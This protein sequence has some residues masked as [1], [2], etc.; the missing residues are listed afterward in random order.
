MAMGYTLGQLAERFD[1]TLRGEA[2]IQIS[3]LAPLGS[4]QSGQLTFLK[5]RRLLTSLSACQAAAVILS[6]SDA[7]TCPLACLISQNPHYDF[8]RVAALFRTADTVE[9]GVHPTA[10]V[11]ENCQLDSTASIGPYCVIGD[12]VK[13]GAGVKLGSHCVLGNQIQIAADT[14]LYARVTIGRDTQ[15]GARCVI[16]SG[17]VI[18]GEGFGLV[19]HARQWHAV[20]QLAGVRIG[21]D[22]DVGA[23][24]TIDRGALVNTCIEDGVKLDNQ[25][26]IGHGVQIG[27]STVIAGCV[28]IGGST[29]IGQGCMIGGKSAIADHLT[30]ADGVIIHGHARVSSSVKKAGEYGSGM[31]LLPVGVWRRLRVRYQQLET[32]FA[33]VA[34]LENEE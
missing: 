18:G 24:T 21:S 22:V 12:D 34:K 19:H 3:S 11:G 28:G 5:D 33:R 26:Q 6:E 32:L 8:A 4:A 29:K 17:V 10:I 20:P 25:I 2:G 13:L 1:L 16:Q 23:N 30:L 7:E 15:I 14:I 31:D 9:P 27:A